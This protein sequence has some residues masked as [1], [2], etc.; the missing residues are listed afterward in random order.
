MKL[1]SN[2]Y[3]ERMKPPFW[4]PYLY[5]NTKLR[6]SF[7][8]SISKYLISSKKYKLLD[9]GCGTKPYKYILVKYCENYVGVDVH[10][11]PEVDYVIRPNEKLPFG[12]EEFDVIISSQ[13]L[14][15]VEDVNLYL[16]E[17]CRLLSKEGYLFLSTHGT[18]QYHSSP[19]DFHRWTA[20]GL[21]RLVESHG[22]KIEEFVPN[23]GQLALTSQLRLNYFYSFSNFLG[24]LGR[25]LLI[26]ISAI[27]QLKMVIED[28]I[29]P[30]RVKERDS[31]AY[32]VVCKK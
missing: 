15:H 10:E 29:T 12:G 7:E 9:Y 3:L 13:V 6:K 2:E 14:E 26:P 30:S 25:F 1:L 28:W 22:F 18:W 4:S 32:L 23:L 27:Y 24:T 11:G 8:H 31:A 5:Y 19:N 21:K 17:C 20:F 16:S